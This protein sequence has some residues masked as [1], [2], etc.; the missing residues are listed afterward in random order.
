MK[1]C[2]TIV[3]LDPDGNQAWMG[4]IDNVSDDEAL[5]VWRY[6]RDVLKNDDTL[7]AG[8]KINLVCGDGRGVIATWIKE[9]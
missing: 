5:R 4:D 9:I 7:P 8:S 6:N 3:I 2:Y 1:D